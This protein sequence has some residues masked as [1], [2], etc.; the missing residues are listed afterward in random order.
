MARSQTTDSICLRT[1]RLLVRK[2]RNFI[3][4]LASALLILKDIPA[5]AEVAAPRMS[6]ILF[7]S[8]FAVVDVKITFF[9]VIS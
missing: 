7:E 8:S 3:A 6:L 5:L 4:I 9:F 1:D 2:K